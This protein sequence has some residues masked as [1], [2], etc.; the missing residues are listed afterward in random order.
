MKILALDLATQGGWAVGEHGGTPLSG[1]QTFGR[2]GAPAEE[3][4]AKLLGWMDDMLRVHQ[5]D[6]V[7]L[8]Q[9]LHPVVLAKISPKFATAELAY[10]LPVVAKMVCRMRKVWRVKY[11]EVQDVREHFVGRRTFRDIT[12]PLTGRTITSREQGKAAVM[13]VCRWNKWDFADDNA[14]DACATWDY[15]CRVLWPLQRG[16]A[17]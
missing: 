3:R 12:C 6:A 17:A 16:A 11:A 4:A 13:N 5:P 15:G 14:A 8:E 2:E 7:V 10:G 1:S 9:P